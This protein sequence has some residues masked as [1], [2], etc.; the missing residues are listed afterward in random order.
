MSFLPLVDGAIKPDY[1]VI[2]RCPGAA[3]ARYAM[4]RPVDGWLWSGGGAAGRARLTTASGPDPRSGRT[5]ALRL[6]IRQVD[7]QSQF[8][9]VG[10]GSCVPPTMAIVYAT[11]WRR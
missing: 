4:R 1:P 11:A 6:Q 3:A 7:R 9:R 8:P 10:S 2:R 5:L